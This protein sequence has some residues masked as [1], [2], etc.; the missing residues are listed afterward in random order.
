MQRTHAAR[1]GMAGAI[2][3]AMA[4]LTATPARAQVAT[5][6]LDALIAPNAYGGGIAYQPGV[7]V[8]SRAR[9]EYESSGVSFGNVVVR[10]QLSES[11]GYESNVLGTR[12]AQGS[13]VVVTNASLDTSSN[14]SNNGVRV[15]LSVDDVRYPSLSQAA[16]CSRS[17]TRIWRSRKLREDWA[18]HSSSSR[19]HIPSIWGQLTTASISADYM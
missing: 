11:A 6:L 4:S 3:L 15:A 12:K 2:A 18:S 9:P 13:A 14:W 16:M 17:G 5:P 1:C 7:T 10:P 19:C 8:T